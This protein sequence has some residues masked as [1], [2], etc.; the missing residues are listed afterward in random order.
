MAGTT[1]PGIAEALSAGK[2]RLGNW[3]ASHNGES[4]GEPSKATVSGVSPMHLAFKFEEEGD[5]RTLVGDRPLVGVGSI[6]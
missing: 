5:L 6:R 2:V 1:V 3:E 4:L